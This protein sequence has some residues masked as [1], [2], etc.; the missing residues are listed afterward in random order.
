MK[1]SLEHSALM[2]LV[3]VFMCVGR[4]RKEGLREESG[5]RMQKWSAVLNVAE[6]VRKIRMENYLLG[7]RD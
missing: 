4:G 7:I 2:L 6:G 5:S 3:I 1:L